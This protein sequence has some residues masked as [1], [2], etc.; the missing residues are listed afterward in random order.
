MHDWYH[1]AMSGGWVGAGIMLVL[2]LVLT[3]GLVAG[4]VVLLRQLTR[5][6][7]SAAEALRILQ[8]RFA[9]GEIDDEEYRRI[10]TRLLRSQ[11]R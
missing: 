7:G 9:H 4:A 1:D 3:G 11:S 10:R 6:A 8:T 5:P 2:V